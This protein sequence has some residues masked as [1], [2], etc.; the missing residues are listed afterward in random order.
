MEEPITA[1]EVQALLEKILPIA[2]DRCSLELSRGTEPEVYEEGGW[3]KAIILLIGWEETAGAR[4]IRDVKE[5]ILAF[6]PEQARHDRA[7]LEQFLLGWAGAVRRVFE[8]APDR[9]STLMPHD[10]LALSVLSLK[11]PVTAAD[12]EAAALIKGRLGRWLG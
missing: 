7:R 12:F 11:K 5:Q 1:A 10:L 9:I 2:T 3:I 8:V 6:V 4:V